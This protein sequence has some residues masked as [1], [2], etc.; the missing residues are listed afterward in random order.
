[1][2]LAQLTLLFAIISL[3]SLATLHIVSR[4]FAPSWRMVSE[5]ALGK[6]RWLITSFF[7]C[8]AI[9]TFLCCGLMTSF[10]NSTLQILGIIFV[11]ISGIGALLGGIFDVKHKKHGLSFLL[12]VPTLPIGA[13]LF[14]YNLPSK[15]NWEELIYLAHA[16]W[17]SLV[18]M[19]IT[20]IIMMNGFKKAGIP[21]GP[22][23][24]S[25]IAVPEGVV[26]VNGYANRLLIICYI[27]WLI[28]IA[29]IYLRS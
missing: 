3:G 17:I 27:G 13:L 19:A 25:P 10:A 1:M 14:A 23:E 24:K 21:L 26:A 7:I 12:G 6:Y 18:I 20:M 4:E 8:W 2:L 29:I 28:T 5:Y 15:K 9:S 22:N 16:T 11:A